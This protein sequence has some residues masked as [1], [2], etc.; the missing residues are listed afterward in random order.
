MQGATQNSVSSASC[1]ERIAAN[2]TWRREAVHRGPTSC[3]GPL[4]APPRPPQAPP[5]VHSQHN[6]Y[7][8]SVKETFGFDEQSENPAQQSGKKR[9][10]AFSQSQLLLGHDISCEYAARSGAGLSRGGRH[11]GSGIEPHA[12]VNDDD[13]DDYAALHGC[14]FAANAAVMLQQWIDATVCVCACSLHRIVCSRL[15]LCIA[16]CWTSWTRRPSRTRAR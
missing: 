15:M 7:S 5:L 3:S 8:A 13:G 10:K 14:N 2:C 4:P 16:G 11:R 1:R 12:E 9:S 6:G